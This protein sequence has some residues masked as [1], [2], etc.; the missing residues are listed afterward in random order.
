MAKYLQ[1]IVSLT[2]CKACWSTYND[3]PCNN[4]ELQGI[5]VNGTAQ[6]LGQGAEKTIFTSS[7]V[8]F[9]TFQTFPDFSKSQYFFFQFEF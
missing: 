8:R 6:S 1:L 5:K 3:C 2:L 9:I 7:A 4:S